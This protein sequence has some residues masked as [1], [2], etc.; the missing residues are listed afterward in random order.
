MNVENE[1]LKPC[2]FCHSE[3]KQKQSKRKE[4]KVKMMKVGADAVRKAFLT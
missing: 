1:E 3:A 2:P 4:A